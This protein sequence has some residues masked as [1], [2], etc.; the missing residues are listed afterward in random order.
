MKAHMHMKSSPEL[1]RHSVGP[2]TSC[3]VSPLVSPKPIMST[4]PIAYPSSSS[5]PTSVP[6]NVVT[7]ESFAPSNLI[8]SSIAGVNLNAVGY[9]LYC[10]KKSKSFQEKSFF[11]ECLLF[12]V[13]IAF[14][15]G[16]FSTSS[17]LFLFLCF[18]SLPFFNRYLISTNRGF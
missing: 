12:V 7:N 3:D 4:T 9:Q 6:P 1:P 11:A 16:V 15:Y 10:Y 14:R 8:T 5:A 18:F 13:F 17:R 2:P